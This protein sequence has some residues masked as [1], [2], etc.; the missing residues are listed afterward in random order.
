MRNGAPF[1]T[2][3]AVNHALERLQTS[4]PKIGFAK[5]EAFRTEK[6][7]KHIRALEMKRHDL[8]VTAQ[9]REAEAS[10]AYARA[11]EKAAVAAGEFEKLKS[12][13]EADVMLIEAWR[14]M[15]ANNRGVRF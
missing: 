13:R 2:D 14:S 4:A 5:A 9:E 12:E 8:G 3:E 10:E 15:N 11:L 7:T 1:I 6:M